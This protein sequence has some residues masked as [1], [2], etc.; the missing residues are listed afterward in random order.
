VYITPGSR[1]EKSKNDWGNYMHLVLLA[2]NNA[3]YRNLIKLVSLG[4]TEGFYY[5][6]RVDL[7]ALERYKEGLIA[8]SGCLSGV[9]SRVLSA[10]GYESAKKKA[11]FYNE[12][13]GKDN[14]YLELGGYE[15]SEQQTLNH[16]LIRISEETGIPLAVTN[17][18]H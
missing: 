14:F 2:E 7:E 12:M 9:I 11:L 15:A 16:T 5:R 18:V 3:G 6:P 4:F 13:F 10:E 17:D 8:L 1:F